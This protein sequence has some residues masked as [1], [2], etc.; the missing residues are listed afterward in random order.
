LTPERV[1][2]L[3]RRLRGEGVACALSESTAAVAALPHIDTEDV[4]DVRAGLR[5]A[6]CSSPADLE[7]FERCFHRL[8]S[9]SL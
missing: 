9:L 3:G 6:F 1:V 4:E 2:D 7:I 8:P 5:A